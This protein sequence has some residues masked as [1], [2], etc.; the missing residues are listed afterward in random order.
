MFSYVLYIQVRSCTLEVGKFSLLTFVKVAD[1]TQI[2]IKMN[3]T[4]IITLL[5][6]VSSRLIMAVLFLIVVLP[7]SSIQAQD[8]D[9]EGEIFWSDD[10]DIESE[11]DEFADEEEFLDDDEYYEDEE[12]GDYDDEEYYEDNTNIDE[13]D[14]FEEDLNVSSKEVTRSGWSVDISGSAARLV[15]YTLWKEYGLNESSWEPSMQGKVSIE[16]PYMLKVLGLRFR[17]GAEVGTF[18]FAD[19]T[20]RGAEL[21]GVSG[22]L[23]AS[24][25]AGPGK[26]KMGTGFFG[27]SM[28]FIFE[29]TYGIALGS[30]DLRVGL[31]STELMSA[32]DDKDKSLGHLGWMDGVMALGVNF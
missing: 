30:L 21:K 5:K 25:P 27:K 2:K 10:E 7:S 4:N 8:P 6:V 26:I 23:L 3:I 22:V 18:G 1:S 28:G 24:I 17:I 9:E 20:P 11:E 29:A 14:E 15:N 31:R 16:A 13:E 12:E 32:I 19:L